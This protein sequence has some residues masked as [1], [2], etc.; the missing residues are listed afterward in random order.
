MY[1]VVSKTNPNG[2]MRRRNKTPNYNIVKR[3]PLRP[4]GKR[5]RAHGLEEKT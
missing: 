3:L 4:E 2:G 1:L 5:F